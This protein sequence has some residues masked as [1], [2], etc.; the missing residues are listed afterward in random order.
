MAMRIKMRGL[1]LS[2]IVVDFEEN[3]CTLY[4]ERGDC[5]TGFQLEK[6]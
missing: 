2:A 6:L 5:I 4:E 3:I 1:K